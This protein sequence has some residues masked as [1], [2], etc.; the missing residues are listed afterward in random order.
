MMRMIGKYANGWCDRLLP[1]AALL[2]TFSMLAGC[3]H[4][5][6]TDSSSSGVALGELGPQPVRPT[7]GV[8]STEPWSF[9]G[10]PGNVIRTEHFR[11]YTTET[12]PVLRDRLTHFLEHALA[13]YRSALVHLPRPPQRLDTY[14]MD[15]RPQWLAVTKRLMGAQSEQLSM[16]QRGGFASRGIGVYYDLG[17]YDTLAIASHEGWHQYTQRTFRDSLPVWAEEGL[18]T[19][20]EG[21]RWAGTTPVFSPWSN[22]ERFEQLRRASAEGRLM[23]FEQ[24]LDGKPQSFL[25]HADDSMLTYYAQLWALIH[26]LNEDEGERSSVALRAMLTDAA[27]GR[28]RQVL[29][30][31]LGPRAGSSSGV[32]SG[33]MVYAAYFGDDLESASDRYEAFLARVVETGSRDAITSGRSPL[34]P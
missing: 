8:L 34:T 10:I 13:H 31:A 9:G 5:L 27:S 23:T 16:I 20:M 4:E 29:A 21:H 11:I 19:F 7:P 1:A 14:L 33:P 15:N 18:A 6:R 3:A 17:L 22:I 30:A 25:G 24:L 32:R 28:L 12:D 26:F 2:M